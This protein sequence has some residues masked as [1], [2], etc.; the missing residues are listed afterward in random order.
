MCG[1]SGCQ[2]APKGF[3]DHVWRTQQ[4][5]TYHRR[6]A[7]QAV[8]EGQHQAQKRGKEAHESERIPLSEAISAGLTECFHCFPPGVPLDA[9]PCQALIDGRWTDAFLLYWKRGPDGRWKGKVNY[10]HNAE[11]RHGLFDQNEL[12][13]VSL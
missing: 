2:A 3:P 9:K 5:R 7:C 12:R 13:P 1:E 10:R 11:R 6:P 4:G 8:T